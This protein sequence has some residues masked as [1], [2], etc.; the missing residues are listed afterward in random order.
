[1][2]KR[3]KGSNKKRDGGLAGLKNAVSDDEGGVVGEDGVL[4]DVER[5][6][7]DEDQ[8]ILGNVQLGRRR[9]DDGGAKEVFALS[10]TDSD[11]DLELPDIKKMRKLKYT[12]PKI[13]V[14]L[15]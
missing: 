13:T 8:R 9:K 4:G 12:T 2:G 7:N 11:S 3:R 10:G 15:M 1:M 6:E 14:L 5:W